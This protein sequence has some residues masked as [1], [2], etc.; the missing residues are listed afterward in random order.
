MGNIYEFKNAPDS[1]LDEVGGKG[2]SLVK[3]TRLGLP[4]PEGYVVGTGAT[5]DEIRGLVEGLSDSYT[6]AV[7]SSAI[8]EDGEGASFAGQYETVTNVSKKDIP[9]AYNTVTKSAKSARVKEYTENMG[10]EESGI[11]IVIQRF[12]KPTFAGVIFTSDVISG[13][14]ARMT[15]NY[16]RGEGE[17]LV[18][19]NANAEVFEIGAMKYAYRGNEEFRKYARKLY[20]YSTKIRNAYGCPMDIEWAVSE[21]KLYILQA[22]PITTLKRI[23]EK[24]Y[25]VNGTLADEYLMT[26]TNVGEIFMKPISP[27]T[28]SV[29]DA[30]NK[31]VGMPHAL[32]YIKG[33]AYMNISVL[34]SMQISLGISEE[35]AF[36]NI[37]DLVGNLP[38]GVKVPVFPFD[39]RA[40]LKNMR[41]ALFGGKKSK[42][43]RKEKHEMVDNLADIA[44]EMIEEIRVLK[45]NEELDKYWDNV[46]IPRLQDGLSAVLAECG[47]Q[48]I[49][50]FSTRNKIR[51]MSDEDMANRL[52]GG[53]LGVLESMKPLLY[54]E[55]VKEG[56]MTEEEYIKACGQRCVCEMEASEPRP[57]ETEGYVK[58]ALKAHEESGINMYEM[59]KTQEEEYAKALAEFDSRY[60]S[61]KAKIRK[62][63]DKFVGANRFRE[64]IRAKGVWL[65]CVLREFLLACGRVNKLGDDIFLLY[66]DEVLKLIKG[67][68]TVINFISSRRENY[69]KNMTYP[70]FPGLVCGRF[71]PDS[72]AADTNRRADVFVCGKD[73]D[74]TNGDVMGFPGAAGKIEGVAR[75]ILDVS[76]IDEL[77]P[78]EI[79]VTCATNIGWTIAFPKASAIVTDIGAPLSHAAIV[80]REFGIPAVVGCGNATTVI[81]N[82]DRICVDGMKGTVTIIDGAQID[83]A[84]IDTS[85]W[86]N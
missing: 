77:K 62:E 64:D 43:S 39:R 46:I 56:R 31:L 53:S 24:T 70:S 81:K 40:F 28:Y 37:R 76:R 41:K 27:L 84:R 67:D 58:E 16:V 1:I 61:K 51:K 18:S 78:G 57:Y 21:G 73:D 42:L 47:T 63:L 26:K 8:N 65:I 49:P 72:W 36:S 83:G 3:L 19:G 86:Q 45:T 23:D 85:G 74:N 75:V 30:I 11:G 54:L 68:L 52:C 35:K 14:S 20:S 25:D 34:C 2:A 80:A 10:S 29:L 71:D 55:D 13:S 15:G 66:I 59:L 50:L 9:E 48:M 79:L 22:R 12:V 69:L 38:E 44:R 5:E 60:P 82:G 7:R 32:D 17:E 33:Q 4:V 6:Y